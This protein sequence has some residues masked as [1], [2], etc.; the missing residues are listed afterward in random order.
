MKTTTIAKLQLILTEKDVCDLKYL[1]DEIPELDLSKEKQ[2]FLLDLQNE[3]D[4][5][6]AN[7]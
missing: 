3:L 5:F 7:G 1:L 6:I 4:E 2:D